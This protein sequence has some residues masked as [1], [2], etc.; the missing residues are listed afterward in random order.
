MVDEGGWR[1]CDVG[2]HRDFNDSMF[3]YACEMCRDNGNTAAAS[4]EVQ[5]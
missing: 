3:L 4:A 1:Q 2:S 5:W